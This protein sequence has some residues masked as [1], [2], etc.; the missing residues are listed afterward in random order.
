MQKQ[1]RLFISMTAMLVL[2]FLLDTMGGTVSASNP[3]APK[4]R[5]PTPTVATSTPIGPSPT[6]GPTQTPGPAPT[7]SSIELTSG[8]SLKSANNVTDPGTTISTVS[9]NVSS[10]YPITVPSTVMAGLIA[11]NVYSN[12]FFGTNLQSVPDL[13][14]QNW[15]YRGQFNAVAGGSGQQYWLRFKGISYRAQIWLNGTLLDSNTVGTLVV[16][17]YNVTNIIVKGGANAVAILVTPP[18]HG[19]VDL[20][21]CTVDWNPEAPDMEAGIWG[22]VLLDT[23]GAVALRDPYVK[24]VL[25]LPATSSAD[26]TVYVDAVNG[27]NTQISGAV[28]GTITKAGYPT[29]NFSQ[30]VTLNPGERKEV[31][32]DPATFTQL[33]VSNPAIWWPYQYGSPELYNL[34]V[35]FVA[36]AQTWDT[37]TIKFGI[38]QMTDYRTTVHGVSFAGYRVNGVNILYRGG[39]YMWDMFARWD[40]KIN[41]AH[42]QYVKDMGLNI[43][44]F[45]GTIGNEEIYDLADQMGILLFGGFVCCSEWE[46]NSGWTTEEHTVAMA[47]ADSQL[48][49]LRSHASVLLWAYGSDKPPTA[50]NLADYKA[51]ATSLHWQNPTLDNVATWANANAGMKMDGPYVWE[52]PLLFWDTTRAGSAFGTTGEEGFEAVPP[53]ES[54]RKFLAPGDLWPIGATFNYHSGSPHTPFDNVTAFSN[55]V[56]NRYGAN[57]NIT[58]YARKAELLNYESVRAFFEAW[59]ANKYTGPDAT[60]GTIFW[61]QSNV[62]PSVHWNLYD[63]Y[64]KP[65]G[66]FYGAKKA[67]EP[68][69]VSYN[70]FN[71]NVQVENSSLITNNAMT[72]SATV[73]NLPTLAEMYTNQ[74]VINAAANATTPAFTIPTISG[75][76]TTYFIRLQVQNSSNQLVSNNLYWYSTTA[77]AFGNKSNWYSTSVST[78]ANLTGLNSLAANNNVTASASR[79]VANGQETVT[80]TLNNTSSTNIAFFTRAEVTAGNNGLEVLPITYTDNYISLFPGESITI[81]AKYATTDLSGQSPF[82]RV[83]GYNVPIFNIAIP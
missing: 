42:M 83:R 15:W 67:N 10:W 22:K 56:N 9:Y 79:T 82:L 45:E 62:W 76:T 27:T 31:T 53:E 7:V 2:I 48:R 47:S 75:L 30:N 4:T 1:N 25:P 52:P 21:F 26:L 16:H 72:V 38:R 78:Y 50:G 41:T 77:D 58:D 70:Y 80:I 55:G 29:I 12:V 71:R 61:M 3:N 34:S 66:G 35:S 8:W 5:T 46:N 49:N 37:K 39:G 68:V 65:G 20:S 6:P 23:T 40:T 14:N 36:N 19:C 57:N 13:T 44:R 59:N 51:I 33:H 18:R 63:Y 54:L 28:T 64:F 69:H 73:Y 81:T 74:V 17:E 11:N 60:F 43:V 32:F 24:T